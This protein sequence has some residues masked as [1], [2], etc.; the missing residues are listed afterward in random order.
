MNRR[1]SQ[2]SGWIG[3]FG[4]GS[5]S[6]ETVNRAF[7]LSPRQAGAREFQSAA[8]LRA[9]VIRPTCR[10]RTRADLF[11]PGIF[12]RLLRSRSLPGG[13]LLRQGGLPG[14]PGGRCLR[15]DPRTCPVMVNKDVVPSGTELASPYVGCAVSH[16]EIAPCG[17]GTPSGGRRQGTPDRPC[18]RGTIRS[19]PQEFFGNPG[20]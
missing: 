2:P 10:W 1:L 5:G 9:T 13:H 20:G 7:P 8:G 17:R 15:A 14:L 19:R 16:S 12:T 3:P 6:P 11:D 4:L 18:L